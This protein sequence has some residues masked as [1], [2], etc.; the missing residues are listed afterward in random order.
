M[1]ETCANELSADL[2]LQILA[3]L[4]LGQSTSPSVRSAIVSIAAAPMPIW[5]LKTY[6]KLEQNCRLL[7][8]E[9][10]V[11]H[12]KVEIT[13]HFNTTYQLEIRDADLRAASIQS[14]HSC[15]HRTDASAMGHRAGLRVRLRSRSASDG[16]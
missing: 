15:V 4:R 7:G 13:G 3:H 9:Y 8:S 6:S 1:L 11:Q 14:G 16:S 12:W 10:Q 2:S 5:V